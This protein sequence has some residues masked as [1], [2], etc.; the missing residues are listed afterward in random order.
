VLFDWEDSGL[1]PLV[2]ALGWLLF[3]AAVASPDRP[4][5]PLNKAAVHA[6]IDG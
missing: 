1:G 4:L 5:T 2:A 6:T 3:T